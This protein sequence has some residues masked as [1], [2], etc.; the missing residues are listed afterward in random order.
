MLKGKFDL[1][2]IKI[3]KDILFPDFNRVYSIGA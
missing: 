1:R 2:P 3:K